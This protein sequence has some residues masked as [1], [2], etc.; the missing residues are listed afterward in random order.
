[1]HEMSIAR[2]LVELLQE[3]MEKAGARTLRSVRLEIGRLSAIVPEA[4]SFGFQVVTTGTELEGA[5]LIMDIIP[6]RCT[7]RECGGGFEMEDY[8]FCCPLCGGVEID[9]L[10]GRELSVKEITV[11]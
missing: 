6:L 9:T 5:E 1:M 4:L 2:S 10:S 3:E 11:D 8:N 7:C